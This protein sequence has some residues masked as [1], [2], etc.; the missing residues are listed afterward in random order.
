MTNTPQKNKNIIGDTD[1]QVKSPAN[2]NS[3]NS[4]WCFGSTHTHKM[5]GLHCWRKLGV[6]CYL[7]MHLFLKYNYLFKRSPRDIISCY[8][9]SELIWHASSS[10][11]VINNVPTKLIWQICISLFMLHGSVWNSILHT[12]IFAVCITV[13]LQYST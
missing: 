1:F 11:S 7:L 9:Y 3:E 2:S 8:P 5:H 6:A 12:Y 10:L 4:N 13:F